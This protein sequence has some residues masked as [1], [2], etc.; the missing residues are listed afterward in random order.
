MVT[1][2][3][4]VRLYALTD[5]FLFNRLSKKRACSRTATTWAHTCWQSWQNSETSTRSS[6][7]SAER[8]Y[9]SV[10]KWSKTRYW[11]QLSSCVRLSA[12]TCESNPSYAIFRP[13]DASACLTSSLWSTG[14]QS[15]AVSSGSEWDLWGCEGHG[16][17][18]RE[19]RSLQTGNNTHL[20]AAFLLC[21][22]ILQ[23]H[24]HPT[25]SEV[26]SVRRL[27]SEMCF[28]FQTVARIGSSVEHKNKIL[29]TFL[30][31]LHSEH[32][33]KSRIEECESS[34]LEN[35]LQKS[36]NGSNTTS[37]LSM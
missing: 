19:R 1:I 8:A 9:R 26:N 16:G 29:Q 10:W 32:F 6:V 22:F 25:R 24:Q 2:A 35:L 23:D 13:Q 36:Q 17:P 21:H 33:S 18:D 12:A 27:C 34:V 31:L 7:T 3:I 37:H 30:C 4:Y 28:Y 14:H 5:G 11:V 20:E 15:P